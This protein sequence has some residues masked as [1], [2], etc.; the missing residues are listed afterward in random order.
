[1]PPVA[2]MDVATYVEQQQHEA[3]M[4]QRLIADAFAAIP[5]SGGSGG[6]T[7]LMF[8]TTGR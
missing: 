8:P 7:D 3:E 1:M 6:R 4:K 5:R 2:G